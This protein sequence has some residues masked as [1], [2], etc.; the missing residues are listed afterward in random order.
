VGVVGGRI[1]SCFIFHRALDL[2]RDALILNEKHSEALRDTQRLGNHSQSEALD[3][4]GAA[5]SVPDSIGIALGHFRMA[6]CGQQVR[7]FLTFSIVHKLD[8]HLTYNQ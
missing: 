5:R 6:L 2:I 3:C 4:L 8:V 7:A 1:A